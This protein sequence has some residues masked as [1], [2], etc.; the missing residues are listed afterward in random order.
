MSY[1]AK[2]LLMQYPEIEIEARLF[3]DTEWSNTVEL[4]RTEGGQI[5]TEIE[6][7]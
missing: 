4:V 5:I 3:L 7:F 6:E 1:A 2:Q